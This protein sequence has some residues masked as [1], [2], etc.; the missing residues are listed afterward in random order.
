MSEKSNKKI[1]PSEAKILHVL[2]QKQ[3][4]SSKQIAEQ[5]INESWSIVT[6]KTLINRLLKKGYLSYEKKGRQYL[7]YSTITK[8]NYLKIENNNFIKRLYNGSLS[9]LFASFS[10]HEKIS[11]E[12]LDKIKL[13]IEQIEDNT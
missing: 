10:E 7:Y 4:L 11:R 2:W 8:E 12:E 5:L 13:I 3:P 6:T 1:S 9:G